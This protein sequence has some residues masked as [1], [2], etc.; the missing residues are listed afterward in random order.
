[1]ADS[2]LA[3]MVMALLLATANET[4]ATAEKGSR[5]DEHDSVFIKQI[6]VKDPREMKEL[7]L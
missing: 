2:R 1:V 3:R 5:T 4:S 7:L 6:A